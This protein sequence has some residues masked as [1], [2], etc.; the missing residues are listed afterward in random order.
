M[1]ITIKTKYL[2]DLRCESV[3]VKSG[4]HLITDAPVDNNGKGSSFSPTDLLA[5]SLASCMLT[6][7]GIVAQRHGLNIDN[8]KCEVTKI[9][10]AAP[11]KVAEIIVTFTFAKNNFSENEKKLLEHAA[12]TCP[13]ALSL[14]PDLEKKVIFNF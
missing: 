7:M 13:V 1:S 4:A 3:H 9:M 14:H 5:T 8:T 12:H 11:R 10:S 2:K 6:I